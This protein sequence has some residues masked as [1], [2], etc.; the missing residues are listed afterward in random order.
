MFSSVTKSNPYGSN[1]STTNS[2]PANNPYQPPQQ[3]SYST[4]YGTR[5]TTTSRYVALSSNKKK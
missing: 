5:A 2:R 1:Q 3:Y 4:P